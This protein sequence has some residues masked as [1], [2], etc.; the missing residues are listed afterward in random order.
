[1]GRNSN[2]RGG[3]GG[4][5]GRGYYNRKPHNS[6]SSSKSKSS[7]STTTKKKTSLQDYKFN[8]GNAKQANEYIHAR[9]YILNYIKKTYKHGDDIFQALS[10]L[11]EK[12]FTGDKP[13]YN[14]LKRI[15]R[16]WQFSSQLSRSS[17]DVREVL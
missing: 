7:T 13:T 17:H 4:R 15:T 1:M 5:G 12:D 14:K 8:V 3:R 9:D 10:T 6:N 2:F 16:V 11:T